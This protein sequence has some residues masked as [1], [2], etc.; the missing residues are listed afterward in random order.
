VL[1]ERC[2][3]L[4]FNIVIV[5]K[6]TTAAD[7]FTPIDERKSQFLTSS[8]IITLRPTAHGII[9]PLTYHRVV[10]SSILVCSSSSSSVVVDFPPTRGRR[11][12]STSI[13]KERIND[14]TKIIPSKSPWDIPR[15]RT[16]CRAIDVVEFNSASRLIAESSIDRFSCVIFDHYCELCTQMDTHR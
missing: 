12:S 2:T 6:F 11:K 1:C 13:S 15:P 14:Y 7:D 8:V 5:N 10:R 9:L 3:T 4:I 16:T